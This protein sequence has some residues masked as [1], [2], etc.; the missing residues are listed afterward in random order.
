MAKEYRCR[1]ERLSARVRAKGDGK[2]LDPLLLIRQLL[3]RLR[4]VG[5]SVFR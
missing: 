2:T 1:E 4:P 5:H 3:Q